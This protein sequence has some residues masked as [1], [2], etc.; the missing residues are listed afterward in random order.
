MAAFVPAHSHLSANQIPTD[1]STC[2]VVV[3]IFSTADYNIKLTHRLMTVTI[4]MPAELKM[5]AFIPA[6]SQVSV[7]QASTNGGGSTCTV[8]QSSVFFDG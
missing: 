5:V 8:L 1:A 3:S 2:T 7:N 4:K 6:Q